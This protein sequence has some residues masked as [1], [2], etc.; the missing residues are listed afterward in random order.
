MN[1]S[2]VELLK[3]LKDSLPQYFGMTESSNSLFDTVKNLNT[4]NII[5]EDERNTLCYIIMSYYDERKLLFDYYLPK[6]KLELNI[7]FLDKLIKK[8]ENKE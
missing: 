6:G 2:K 5:S 1:R 8:Y 3:I 7:E 4:K